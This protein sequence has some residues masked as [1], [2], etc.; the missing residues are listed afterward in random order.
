MA[1][2]TK[3]GDNE[4]NYFQYK[5]KQMLLLK[6]EEREWQE[7]CK[8]IAPE[9]V[10]CLAEQ[11][12]SKDIGIQAFPRKPVNELSKSNYLFTLYYL[13]QLLHISLLDTF[14]ANTQNMHY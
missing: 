11:V 14:R 2:Y 1:T 9:C 13:F 4:M 10:A 7:F 8:Q 6:K 5:A 3:I 12:Q